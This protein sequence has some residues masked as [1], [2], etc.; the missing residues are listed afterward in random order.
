[1]ISRILFPTADPRTDPWPSSQVHDL[2]LQVWDPA[3]DRRVWNQLMPIL[4]PSYPS[5]NS[6][7]NVNKSTLQVMTNEFK[8]GFALVRGNR[9]P[10][11]LR[12]VGDFFCWGRL[13]ASPPPPSR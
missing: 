8:R 9:G 3:T 12:L 10:K 1:M 4:T 11:P 5:S 2:G 13:R 7:Y 6:A